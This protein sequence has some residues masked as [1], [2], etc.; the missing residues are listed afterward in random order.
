MSRF[1]CLNQKLTVLKLR[2]GVS[3]WLKTSEFHLKSLREYE[4]ERLLLDRVRKK[5]PICLLCPNMTPFYF[6]GSN[7]I[8]NYFNI[9]SVKNINKK[10]KLT[11]FRVRLALWSQV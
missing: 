1:A 7:V 5:V 8:Y 10:T 4:E 6:T 2:V 9:M 3:F 11:A